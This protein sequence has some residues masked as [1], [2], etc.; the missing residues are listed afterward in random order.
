[1]GEAARAFVEGWV[2]ENVHVTRYEPELDP[3]LARALAAACLVE[4]GR[5]GLSRLAIYAAVGDLSRYM[6]GALERANAAR[7]GDRADHEE[8]RIGD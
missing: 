6:L 2:S 1:M 5:R 4:A 7:S 8:P 3:G